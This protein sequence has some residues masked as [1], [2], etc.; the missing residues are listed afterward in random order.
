MSQMNSELV[1]LT[2]ATKVKLAFKL[3]LFLENIEP[4]FT[5]GFKQ[6]AGGETPVFCECKTKA[7]TR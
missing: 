3:Q 1:H 6:G 5:A 2:L 7:L 4:F